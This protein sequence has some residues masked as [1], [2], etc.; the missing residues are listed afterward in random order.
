MRQF[1]QQTAQN[2]M[3]AAKSNIY[4]WLER[5][6]ISEAHSRIHSNKR[7][8][9]KHQ[10]H[11]KTIVFIFDLAIRFGSFE[12]RESSTEQGLTV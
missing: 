3:S 12:W 1:E 10:S 5:E 6:S 9:P 2:R 7:T 11:N 8:P 4:S